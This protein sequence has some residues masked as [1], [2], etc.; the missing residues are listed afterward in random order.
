M[1]QQI[2][3]VTFSEEVTEMWVKT[4]QISCE[5]WLICT[6]FETYERIF[7][8]KESMRKAEIRWEML[9]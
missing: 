9:S 5:M 1:L 4:G 6:K 8:H 2:R 3:G 7:K